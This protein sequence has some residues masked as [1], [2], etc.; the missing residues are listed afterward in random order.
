[1]N[2]DGCIE[3]PETCSVTDCSAAIRRAHAVLEIREEL[4]SGVQW[5]ALLE[6]LVELAKFDLIGFL[7]LCW[8]V[9]FAVGL[10]FFFFFFEFL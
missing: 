7:T 8:D 9:L 1:M 6:W 10:A 2:P 4:P 5:E 3:V